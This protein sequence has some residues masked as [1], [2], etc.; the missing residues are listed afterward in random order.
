MTFNS[1]DGGF[2]KD[3]GRPRALA[4]VHERENR[5]R[6]FV[7]RDY[8]EVRATFVAATGLYEP[9]DRSDF[10]KDDLDPEKSASRGCG[11]WPPPKAWSR[12]AA[13]GQA[14]SAEE[15]KPSTQLS[16][17]LLRPASLQ[18]EANWPL[19]LLGEGTRWR[20]RRRYGNAPRR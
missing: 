16:P 7:S 17:A 11:R 5:I 4:I 20:W 1:K 15:S 14:S 9:L 8:W 3:A 12:L 6:A 13:T 2:F 19:R 10:K 18:R